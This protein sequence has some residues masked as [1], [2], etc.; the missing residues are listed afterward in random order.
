LDEY[1][2]VELSNAETALLGLLSEQPMYPYQIEQQ[3]KYRDMR[4]WTDLS[5]SSIYKLLKKLEKDKLITRKDEVSPENRLQKIYTISDQGKKALQ[6][7]I[8]TLLS[9]PEHTKW[10]IDIGTYNL[11]LIPSKT[12]QTALTKYRTVLQ[13]KIQDYEAL[14]K[15]L[16]DEECPIYRHGVASRPI[17]LLKAEVQWVDEFLKQID[18]TAGK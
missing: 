14:L 2:M 5:M 12:A 6:E 15:F 4:S 3:V 9:E 10:Q 11:N 17:L 13:K 18:L 16:Q 7:K 8:H 1:N